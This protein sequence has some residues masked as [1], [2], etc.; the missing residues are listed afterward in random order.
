[1]LKDIHFYLLC[2]ALNRPAT[3]LGKKVTL[4]LGLP[5]CALKTLTNRLV[6]KYAGI[7]HV[8]YYIFNSYFLHLLHFL[9]DAK[10][11]TLDAKFLTLRTSDIW[12]SDVPKSDVRC[13]WTLWTWNVWHLTSEKWHL[14]SDVWHLTSDIGHQM[15]EI[16]HQTSDIW[17]KT[18]DISRLTSDI[19]LKMCDIWHHTSD[20]TLLIN[21]PLLLTFFFKISIY[22]LP[23]LKWSVYDTCNPP[24]MRHFLTSDYLLLIPDKSNCFR[25]PEGSSYWESTVLP[26]VTGKSP[27]I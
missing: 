13:T 5:L 14:T 22:L 7:S 10:F 18:S 19:R 9:L 17:H 6:S 8:I 26:A 24:L 11:L 16:S 21:Q 15:F 20:I 2:P 3:I 4:N 27:A 12:L 25:F 23:A 1:M